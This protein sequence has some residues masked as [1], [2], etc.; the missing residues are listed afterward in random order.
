MQNDV[1]VQNDTDDYM[2]FDI[3]DGVVND[4]VLHDISDSE[5]YS[6]GDGM[7]SD[8]EIIDMTNESD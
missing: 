6:D 1:G 8:I 5:H 2:H 7:M 4:D 3:Y